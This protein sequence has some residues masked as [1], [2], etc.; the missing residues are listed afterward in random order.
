M[1]ELV[2][3]WSWMTSAPIQGGLVAGANRGGW[4]GGGSRGGQ[5]GADYRGGLAE[6]GGVHDFDDRT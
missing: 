4:V 6:V 5:V 3:S 1:V 2:D